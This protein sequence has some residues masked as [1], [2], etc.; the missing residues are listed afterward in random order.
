MSTIAKTL[1]VS[2]ANLG[3]RLRGTQAIRPNHYFKAK[4][5]DLL[6]SIKALCTQRASYGYRRITALINRQ[7]K[8]AGQGSVNHKR[9][10]RIMRHNNLLL[11]R[12]TGK[13]TRTHDGKVV[14]LAS[15]MRWSADTFTIKCFNSE[16]VEV[17]FCIDTC[18]REI[19]NYVA[20]SSATNGEMI[21]DLI[22]LS[23]EARFKKCS[24]LPRAIEWLSDNGPP[25][26]AHD[27]RKF[28][29][30]LGFT[31]CSTPS[32]SPESNGVSEAF[33]KTF[34][35]D[36]VYLNEL[37]SAEYVIHQL[38]GWFEDYNEKAP[39]KGLK[40]KSPR[41]FRLEYSTN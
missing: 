21:R 10:Y 17:S 39:H 4:D 18:D 26:I 15:N 24:R 41:E 31:M 6:S 3:E 33:V 9:I 1:G 34:K 38:A 32:Y 5:N 20:T 22:A 19:I 13:S 40:M 11:A 28:G 36:Y 12:Y 29:E 35:R 16:K 7:L 37:Y 14:T 8:E 2:R 23:F 30:S 25:Y 27:T